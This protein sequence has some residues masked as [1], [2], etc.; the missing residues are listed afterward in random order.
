M[1][2]SSQSPFQNVVIVGTG[3]IGTRVAQQISATQWLNWGHKHPTRLVGLVNSGAIAI[4]KNSRLVQMVVEWAMTKDELKIQLQQAGLERD[5]SWS[6]HDVIELLGSQW[7]DIKDVVV[8]DTTADKSSNMLG[9]HKEV[10]EN[11][12]KIATANKNPISLFGMDDFSQLTEE[13]WSYRYSA[14]VMA[15]APGINALQD[16]YDTH[17]DVLWIEWCFSGTLGF[18]SSGIESRKLSIVLQEA[19]DKNYTEPNPWDDLNGLDVA[20]KILILARTAGFALDMGDVTVEPFLPKEFEKYSKDEIVG[21]VAEQLDEEWEE[22]MKKLQ[23]SGKTLRYIAKL[24]VDKYGK[25][26]IQVWLQEVDKNSPLWSL[27]GTKNK[28]TIT[29][30]NIGEQTFEQAWAGTNVTAQ[31]VINDLKALLPKTTA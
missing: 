5:W 24:E 26:T 21:A 23:S 4:I 8:V 16:A 28:I 25:P 6:Y 9:F 12:G 20:R 7:W 13:R 22:R 17:N 15:G 10:L 19:M 1:N 31:W 2:S 18:L 11:G 14:S 3:G 29:T 27:S 30:E